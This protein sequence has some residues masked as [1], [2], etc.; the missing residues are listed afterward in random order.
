[1][2]LRQLLGAVRPIESAGSVGDTTVRSVTYDSRQAGP[3]SVFVALRGVKADGTSFALDA[4]KRG[5][6]AVVSRTIVVRVRSEGGVT[7][8]PR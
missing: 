5:A 6:I 3:G 8:C 2:T 7:P 4:I 1:M